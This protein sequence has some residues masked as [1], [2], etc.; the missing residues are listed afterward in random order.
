MDF[1]LPGSSL[2]RSITSQWQV[3]GTKPTKRRQIALN[4]PNASGSSAPSSPRGKSSRMASP[5]PGTPSESPLDVEALG[6]DATNSTPTTATE[7]QQIPSAEVAATPQNPVKRAYNDST[8]TPQSEKSAAPTQP[9]RSR[10]SR[11]T[12]AAAASKVAHSLPAFAS[13]SREALLMKYPPPDLDLTVLGG[14]AKPLEELFSHVVFPLQHPEVYEHLQTAPTRGILLHGVPGGG[15]T[16]LVNCLAGHFRIPLIPISAPSLVSSL[17]GDTEKLLRQTFEDAKA[18]APCILFLDEVDAITPK[19][20][21]AQREMEK[22]IVGQLLTCMDDLA[23]NAEHVSVIAATN[24]PDSL[25]PALRRAGR[26]DREIEMGVPGIEA[27][28]EILKVLCSKLRLSA[29]ID[30][31]ALAMATPGYVGADLTALTAAAGLNAVKRVFEDLGAGKLALPSVN[32]AESDATT[33]STSLPAEAAEQQVTEGVQDMM[34]IDEAEQDHREMAKSENVAI[35]ETS[36]RVFAHLPATIRDTPIASFLEKYPNPL[37]PHQ[38]SPLML[39]PRD[40]SEALKTIQP[41]AKREGFATVPDVTWENVGALHGIRHELHMAIVQPIRRPEFFKAVG[42][43]EPSGVL[44]WGPPGC[45]KTLLAK[46]VANESRANFIS[47]KGPELLNKYVGESEKAIR[48][49]FERARTSEP[50]VIFFDELDA[51]VPRRDES[52]SESSARVVNMLLTELDGLNS[53][54]GVFVIGATN[55]PDMI[56][57]AMVR[58]GRLDK[59]LYVDL[60][61]SSERIEILK[62]HMKRT[63]LEEGAWQ[64]VMD[65]VADEKCD[66]YSGADLAALVREAAT[67]ALR[68]ALEAVGAFENDGETEPGMPALK[69]DAAP[70]TRI[71]VTL[72]HFRQAAEK[73]MP[74][75]S[76]EQKKKYLALRDKFA[77]IPTNRKRKWLDRNAQP[78]AVGDDTVGNEAV[79]NGGMDVA[80]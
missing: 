15:K 61:S 25:D 17:S 37:T 18:L 69:Q 56:D 40:F 20:E 28:E 23:T 44:L 3:N 59:L 66:G 58:P 13:H 42:I 57:P 9:K 46:A 55:R 6:A 8:I 41:T 74:S 53:R 73:T 75:V 48:S 70:T 72:E 36:S 26:F 34:V 51:L 5:A 1:P 64:G 11:T 63:P 22:R 77:G 52:M 50:C 67:L 14:L 43:S 30:Y 60:P 19:R 21:T 78:D 39:N 76:R 47:V 27:R 80:L 62:T 29:E 24:R 7:Q 12:A 4:N 54:K 10:S 35:L 79:P 32:A 2:N 33:P 45:G 38:L 16:R 65:I 71:V 31:H 68:N 49:V